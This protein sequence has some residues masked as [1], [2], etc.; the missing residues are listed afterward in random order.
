MQEISIVLASDNNYAMYMFV[1]ILSILKN[2][3]KDSFLN[4]YLLLSPDVS[5]KNKD[6]LIKHTA[7]YKN[8]NFTFIDMK[9]SFKDQKIVCQHITNSTYYRLKMAELINQD[10][11][12]YLDTDIIIK[13]DLQ[14]FYNIDFEDNYIIGI[15]TF[16]T[17]FAK[18]YL[19]RNGLKDSSNYI[20]AG[21][22][23]W[24]LKKIREENI[25]PILC[26]EAKKNHNVVDQDVINIV[27][28]IPVHII[29][30]GLTKKELHQQEILKFFGGIKTFKEIIS[31]P[32]IIHYTSKD[33][34]W[35][36]F[37]KYW[38]DW[39]KYGVQTPYRNS[40]MFNFL[41]LNNINFLK[42]KLFL[43]NLAIKTCI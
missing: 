40:L 22:T 23:I 35:N 16:I 36:Q 12:L 1:T 9:D 4:F 37:T 28:N 24:N 8:K 26:E 27:F 41:I 11:V 32:Y 14:D 21:V 19:Y 29:K 39:W 10:K 34:P 2:A 3:K 30:M 31:N 17:A 6:L 15:K 33:K 43:I 20:N 38:L 5:T 7:K 25:T 18:E 42:R 13:K